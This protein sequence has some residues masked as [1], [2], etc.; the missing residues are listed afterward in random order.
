MSFAVNSILAISGQSLGDPYL[1]HQERGEC[2]DE[3]GIA[4]EEGR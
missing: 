4:L 1:L 2:I 3:A